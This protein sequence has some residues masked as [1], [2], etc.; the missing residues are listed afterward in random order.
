MRYLCERNRG[1]EESGL[2]HFQLLRP[3]PKRKAFRWANHFTL[4]RSSFALCSA[5]WNNI[6]IV[7]ERNLHSLSRNA[8]ISARRSRSL[9]HDCSARIPT[10]AMEW[11][12]MIRTSMALAVD[13]GMF[14]IPLHYLPVSRP[15]TGR[16][17][18]M[19]LR[20]PR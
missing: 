9:F 20:M 12:E 17:E 19:S 10:L 1:K 15:A 18:M 2:G 7:R 3:F 5:L 14:D 6:A 13:N 4:S 11:F 8:M 16:P